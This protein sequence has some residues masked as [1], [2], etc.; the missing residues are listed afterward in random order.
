MRSVEVWMTGIR[1]KPRVALEA[2]YG[3]R[4]YQI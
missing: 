2:D 1:P 3:A 4:N